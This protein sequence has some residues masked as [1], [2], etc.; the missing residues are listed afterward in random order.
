MMKKH[1][2][3]LEKQVAEVNAQI[4]QAAHDNR[5]LESQ[6]ASYQRQAAAEINRRIQAS[7]EQ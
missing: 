1:V 3:A 4:D 2:A 7:T 5:H 6:L